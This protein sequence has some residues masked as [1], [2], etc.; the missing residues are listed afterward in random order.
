MVVHTHLRPVLLAGIL[1]F[2]ALPAGAQVKAADLHGYMVSKIDAGSCAVDRAR[3]ARFEPRMVVVHALVDQK[4]LPG[5]WA[6]A[7]V[8]QPILGGTRP[9]VLLPLAIGGARGAR[10]VEGKDYLISMFRYGNVYVVDRALECQ[11]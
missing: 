5:G 8:L 10:F 11:A 1:A 7:K 6:R 4:S 2:F 3:L 9:G